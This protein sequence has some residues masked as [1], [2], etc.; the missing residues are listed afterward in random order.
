[1]QIK[2]LDHI[3]IRVM[4]VEKSMQFYKTLGF[5]GI[6]EDYKEQVFVVKHPSG[7]EI[8]LIAHGDNDHDRRNILMDVDVRYPGYTHYA[9][10]VGSV[11]DAKAFF[12][13]INI[14]ITGGPVTFGDGKTS[15]FIRDPDLNV[16]EFT[17]L[18]TS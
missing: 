16:L 15:I 17:E 9:S 14:K 11:E 1:M 3:G 4:N 5:Q 2:K 13:S 7:I 6:R 10:E 8:N 18:P 12:E